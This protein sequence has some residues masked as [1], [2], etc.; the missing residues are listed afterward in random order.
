MKKL[1]ILI[2]FFFALDNQISAQEDCEGIPKPIPGRLVNDFYNKIGDNAELEIEELLRKFN[3]STSIEIAVITLQDITG[4]YESDYATKIGNCWGVGKAKYN[5]GIVLLV[6]FEG[7]KAWA[8]ATGKGIEQYLTDFTAS[9]LGQENLIPNLQSG[10]IDEAFKSTVNA[11]INHLGW[12]DW[13]MREYWGNWDKETAQIQ[14]GYSKKETGRGFGVFFTWLLYLF[15]I[16][17]IGR[18]I[19]KW[20]EEVTTRRKHREEIN[21]KTKE[22]LQQIKNLVSLKGKY[23]DI[24]EEMKQKH[25]KDV[26]KDFDKSL[27]TVYD[28]LEKAE[29]NFQKAFEQNKET[30]N[31]DSLNKAYENY[32]LALSLLSS[33][34]KIYTSIDNTVNAQENAKKEYKKAEHSAKV[35]LDKAIK[36]CKKEKV[37]AEAKKL[38]N[39][40]EDKM[41]KAEAMLSSGLIDWVW[42]VALFYSIED[43]AERSYDYK[44]YHSSSSS[45]NSSY[46]SSYNPSSSSHSS[47]SFGGF[48]GGSFG[49]GGAGGHW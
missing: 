47:S 5:N 46:K 15:L 3:D 43:L 25:P 44:E 23:G 14:K 12:R 33:V 27:S 4:E 31:V 16:G 40:A 30:R 48:G 41:E 1:L 38:K 20:N 49:G 42:L 2:L 28:V 45:S 13:E 26:W 7:D 10:N 37:E 22:F 9:S 19:Y 29:T 11:I 32:T 34:E 39:Q 8:I 21:S 35:A 6:S 17:Y 24:V 36:E 18:C